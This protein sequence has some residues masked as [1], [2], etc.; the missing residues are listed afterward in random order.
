MRMI[1][2]RLLL[3]LVAMTV[4]AAPCL[5]A[6]P[7]AA[8][9]A[10]VDITPPVP[11][12]MCGYF[13]ERLSTGTHDPLLA[14]AIVLKQGQEQ[15]ALVF[16]DLIGIAPD[17]AARARKTASEKTG[18][19]VANIMVAATHSHTG[20]LYY[21][22]LRDFYHDRAVAKDGNDPCEKVD[23]AAQLVDGIVKAIGDAR[24]AL[25]PVEL[26]AGTTQETRLSFNR[27]FHMKDGSVQ[28]NP[29]VK[30][31][32]IVRTAGPIDPQ[33]G[34]VLVREAS[35]KKPVASLAVF[36]LHLDTTGGTAYS[37]D[38]PYYL[39]RSLG[40]QFGDKF[41]SFF[42]NGT[43]GDVNHID[44]TASKQRSAEEIGTALAETVKAGLARLTPI[45]RPSLAAASEI[46]PAPIQKYSA[47]EIARAKET[48]V[49]A[50]SGG[51]SF[52]DQV[53]AVKIVDLQSRKG[54]V[55]PL[56]V[57][58]F[59]L[60]DDVALVTLPAEPFVDLGLAIKQ[61]SPF[62]T[63]MV[64]ELAN[65]EF[66]YIPTAK[67]FVEGSYE[68][69]NSPIESGGGEMLVEATVRLLKQLKP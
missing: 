67:A 68:T 69:V 63:T 66:A 14:K 62:A 39:A 4:A 27:R 44:V 28:F 22:A 12:R 29:G 2:P 15:I 61:R 40:G 11:Y 21:S 41:V 53:K 46:V 13:S 24:A 31:P 7:I 50:E 52:L 30:N 23:Y 34:L 60:G 42:G 58:V 32:D 10:V 36:A 64:V 8:G 54:D 51:V 9:V 1:L 47:E 17:L 19:P 38:F 59:R 56:E 20:P 16:C 35:D 33:V 26:Q 49:K 25:R 57:Q 3:G 45:E 18:I 55:L 43:C 5:S 6:E 37:A 48:M 65:D